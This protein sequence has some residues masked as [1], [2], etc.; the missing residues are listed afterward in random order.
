MNTLTDE[1]VKAIKRGGQDQKKIF[2]AFAKASE[3]NGKPT[4]ILVK[5]VKGDGMGAQGKK[6]CASI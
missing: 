1:E 5:T 3:P 4:V 2:A 6:Y